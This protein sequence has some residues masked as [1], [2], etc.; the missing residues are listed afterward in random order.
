MMVT[1][2]GCLLIE[3]NNDHVVSE[4]D[5]NKVTSVWNENHINEI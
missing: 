5:D 2:H 3:N 1:I 4:D